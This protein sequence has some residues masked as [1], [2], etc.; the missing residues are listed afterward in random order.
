VLADAYAHIR[1][2]NGSLSNITQAASIIG[3]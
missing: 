3:G 1:Q 2:Q